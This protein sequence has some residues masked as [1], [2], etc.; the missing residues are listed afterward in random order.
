MTDFAGGDDWLFGENCVATNGIIHG[1]L[2]A[3]LSG[4]EP[5]YE[6]P[7]REIGRRIRGG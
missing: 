2:R 5:G 3:E 7:L 6:P 1:E 4:T